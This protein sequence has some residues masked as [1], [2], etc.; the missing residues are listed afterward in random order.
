MTFRLAASLTVCL[1]AVP[2]LAELKPAKEPVE[3]AGSKRTYVFKSTPEGNLKVYVYLPQGWKAG[4]KRPV[5]VMFHGGGF[6]RGAPEQFWTKAAYLAGRGMV[7]LT[8][9]YRLRSRESANPVKSPWPLSEPEPTYTDATIGKTIEDAKSAIRWVRTNAKELGIDPDRVA[10]S[11]GSAG[12]TCAALAALTNEL[13]PGG[14]D[15]SVSSKPNVLVL[16]NPALSLPGARSE[17]SSVSEMSG[18]LS[19]WKVEKGAP[20]MILFFGTED[21]LLTASREMAR[22]SAMLGNRAELY[23]AAGQKHGFFNDSDNP[24]DGTSSPGWHQVVLY[25]TDLFLSSL[26]YL[27]GKP[28]VRP[29]PKLVLKR[30]VLAKAGP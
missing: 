14:E 4:Q 24:A 30:E 7:A 19:S 26:G 28:T 2:A 5:I 16:Y 8:P 15:L 17:S 22:Q 25:Q 12:G 3:S 1:V 20:P 11:G 6:T 10:G 29:D 21:R 18:V 27:K 13:E 23:T 9:Q